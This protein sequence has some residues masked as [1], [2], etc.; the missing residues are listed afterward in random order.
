MQLRVV[1]NS[2]SSS[3]NLTSS[4]ITDIPDHSWPRLLIF[5]EY[6]GCSSFVNNVDVQNLPM[7]LKPGLYSAYCKAALRVQPFRPHFILCFV[8]NDLKWFVLFLGDEVY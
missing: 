8:L 1:P 7:Y 5:T 6:D 4:G 3:V 2:S